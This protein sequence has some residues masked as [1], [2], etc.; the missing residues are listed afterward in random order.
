MT[1]AKGDNSKIPRSIGKMFR[2]LSQRAGVVETYVSVLPGDLTRAA[3]ESKRS[4]DTA[5]TDLR[6]AQATIRELLATVSSQSKKLKIA[7][8]TID[9]LRQELD[10]ALTKATA[11]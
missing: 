11:N 2:Y 9:R 8:A 6:E 4:A 3:A 5:E 10:A 1:T 7:H